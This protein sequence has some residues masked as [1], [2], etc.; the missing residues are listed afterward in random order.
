VAL[1]PKTIAID[2]QLLRMFKEFPRLDRS[3]EREND[4]G[5]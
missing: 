4:C 3:S 1:T 2:Y 5:F